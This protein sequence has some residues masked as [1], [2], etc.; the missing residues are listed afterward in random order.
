MTAFNLAPDDTPE[1]D[2]P[3]TALA[4]L[5]AGR[6]PVPTIDTTEPIRPEWLRSWGGFHS[7]TSLAVRRA[8][9]RTGV[10][11]L[12]LP[13]LL[14]LL[15]LY[16][17]R[18]LGRLVAVLGRYLYDYDSAQVR[19]A[20]AAAVE[21]KEYVQAQNVRRANLKA[22]WMV[23]GTAGL[24]VLGPLFAWW[25]PQVL[26]VA[27]G[28]AVFM[29]TVK[30]IPGQHWG[31]VVA[32]AGLGVGVWYW[33]PDLLDRVPQPPAWALLAALAVVVLAL[34][35]VGRPAG[36]QMVKRA[37]PR[38]A[39]IVEKPTAPMVVDALVRLGIPGLAEKTRDDIRVFAPG[40]ARSRRGYH[41]SMELPAGV[42]AASVMDRREEFA[43]A[44]RRELGTCWPA[45]GTRHPGHLELFISDD[46]MATAPQGR[47]KVADG[48]IRDIFKPIELFTDQEGKWVDLTFAYQQ[49]VVGGAPGYGKSFAVRQLGVAAAFDPRVRIVCMDGKGNGDLRPLRL[50]AHGF[51]EGDEPDEIAEQLA[52][53]RAIREEMR[54]RARFL[55]DLPRDEN[56]ESKV[57]SELADRYPHL[58]PI[59]ILVDEVQVYSEY[60]DKKI[61]EEFVALFTDIVKRGRSAAIIPVFCTQ[62]PDAS[63]LPSAIASNCSIRLCFRV[64]DWK[65]NDQVLGTGMHSTGIKATL[66]AATDKGLAWLKGDGGDP[67]VV[68]TAFGLD[69][70]RS[71]ELMM[72]ARSLREGRGLLTGQAAGEDAANEAV[73][74]DL[75]ADV[76]DVMDH[77]PVPR[78]HLAHV[79]ERLVLLRP[80]T[81]G[82]L[83]VD[84]L[85]GMLR[86]AGVPVGQVKVGG[87]NTSGVRRES[88]NIAATSDEDP[89][90][91]GGVVVPIR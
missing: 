75:L 51:Y 20:H 73:Q 44:L 10:F 30:L 87:R 1:P 27:A 46:P 67:M 17:P 64:N 2:E 55:R 6:D 79:L 7:A 77:P 80:S 60:A 90:D 41:L 70:V 56:P 29:W 13:A 88:L 15:A 28:L 86:Q 25:A 38:D 22:R 76:R 23:A 63:A 61:R 42:T 91:G 14:C 53:V 37:D 54:R 36:K 62:K 21:T 35:W 11:L 59:L 3:R 52:A 50:V 49:L 26:A 69:A 58:A 71:E 12:H 39:G 84:A 83:D 8:A 18:G 82:H 45:K 78:M 5:T 72:T 85:G 34:G 43:A 40:V 74:V 33:T 48:E 4:K 16:S 57:T 89:D 68:R 24:V 47:W 9:Y 66:F 31:E 81:W 65:S 32:A 19:H